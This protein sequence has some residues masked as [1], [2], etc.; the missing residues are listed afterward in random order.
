M[1]DTTFIGIIPAR[2]GSTRFPAKPLAKLGGMTVIERVYRQVSQ[3]LEHVVVA[4]DDE[5][6]ADEVTRFG[7]TAVMT[8]TAHRS[9][10]DRCWEAY[11]KVG[12]GEDV[13]I[14]IQGDEPFI[15]PEQLRALMGCFAVPETHIATLLKPFAPTRPY[16]DLENPNVVKV[17]TDDQGRALYFS[18]S[19]IPY[20]RGHE[21]A[22]WPSLKQYFTHV[23]LYAYRSHVLE[24][25]TKL[26]QSSLEIAESLEQL[27]WLENGLTIQT[28]VTTID[29]IGIDTPDDL[30]RAEQFLA[31]QL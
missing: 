26:P 24:Q 3:V 27:R 20:M 18:R 14:N 11:Q 12:N 31:N 15:Q 19:V 17:V 6:I 9:G 2:Y 1:N 10:T 16:A 8:S 7:G 29:T 22:E 28:A 4:T 5:R 30:R 21:R 13:V 25:V 23:G